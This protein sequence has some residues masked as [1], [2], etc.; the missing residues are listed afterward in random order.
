MRR[1]RVLLFQLTC[2]GILIFA[3]NAAFAD[4]NC[5]GSASSCSFTLN[6]TGVAGGSFVNATVTLNGV[7]NATI[8]FTAAPGDGIVAVSSLS[9][10][11]NTSLGYSGAFTGLTSNGLGLSNSCLLCST[12]NNVSGFGTF[13]L[14]FDQKNASTPATT[15][16][17]TL[18]GGGWSS[19]QQVLAFNSKGDSAASHVSV[20]G[21]TFYVGDGAT[22]SP[23][24]CGGTSVSE[25]SVLWQLL[26]SGMVAL[27]FIRR[28]F[29]A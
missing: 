6:N 27:P 25:P 26:A 4:S 5:V 3:A 8:Q 12:G 13:N 22:T 28:R 9:L 14:I 7:G 29:L 18:T 24:S 19:A 15:I 11:V 2:I 17:V 16:S 21:C 20:N 10:N 1:F 23:A